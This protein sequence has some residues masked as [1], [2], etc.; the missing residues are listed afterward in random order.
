MYEK[1]VAAGNG[2]ADLW[3]DG[4]VFGSLRRGPYQPGKHQQ[5][6]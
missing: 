6:K 5:I 4:F 1:K 2:C 3:S